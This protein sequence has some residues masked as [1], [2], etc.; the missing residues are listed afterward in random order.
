[1]LGKARVMF[2]SELLSLRTFH[3]LWKAGKTG[4]TRRNVNYVFGVA[5]IF[6]LWTI[7]RTIIE[8]LGHSWCIVSP[9][10][11]KLEAV[12]AFA[13]LFLLL[14]SMKVCLSHILNEFNDTGRLNASFRLEKKSLP[15]L[16][17]A[18]NWFVK[19]AYNALSSSFDS[20]FDREDT[21]NEISNSPASQEQRENRAIQRSIEKTKKQLKAEMKGQFKELQLTLREMEEQSKLDM[22]S[23]QEHISTAIASAVAES[24]QLTQQLLVQAIQSD[25][26]GAVSEQYSNDEDDASNESGGSLSLD[27]INS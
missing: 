11:V 22:A 23:I 16:Q 1:M 8:K 7:V 5:A 17:G 19:M 12:L 6:H 27:Q 25:N 10:R 18:I 3:Q 14:L 2:V 13:V 24:Q 9:N 26:G 21:K 4:S 20:L 15:R